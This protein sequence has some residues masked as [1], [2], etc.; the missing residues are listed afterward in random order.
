MQSV[1]S[2]AKSSYADMDDYDLVQACQKKNEAAFNALYKRYRSHVYIV[3]RRLA[4]DLA[5]NHDDF[6][7][8][9]FVR[10]WKSIDTLR[11]PKAFKTWLNRLTANLFYDELRRRPKNFVISIDQPQWDGDDDGPLRE[12]ED[13]KAQP[14]ENCERNEIIMHVNAALQN[15]PEHSQKVI[16]LRE[17]QGLSYEEIARRT[18][19]EVGTVKS[20]ISRARTKM[21]RRLEKLIA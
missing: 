19:T 21:Q 8:E 12:I 20:R 6:V 14:D 17:F 10:V 5:Q 11:N 4:P 3:L 18:K 7:Q 2:R 15:L 16:V 1:M 9:V 13:T